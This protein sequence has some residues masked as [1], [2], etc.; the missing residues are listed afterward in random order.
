MGV[1]TVALAASAVAVQR[2]RPEII[3]L[4]VVA[5][6]TFC[7]S[8]LTP[9]VSLLGR[10]PGLVGRV[11]WHYALLPMAFS[12]A[13]LGGIGLNA[14]VQSH[15]D[16]AV[17]RWL[18]SWFA[19]I[20]LILVAIWI[21]GRGQLPR[22]E[23]GIRARSFVWP[24]VDTLVGLFVVGALVIRHRLDSSHQKPKDRMVS[25]TERPVEGSPLSS[26]AMESEPTLRH[27]KDAPAA[28][29]ERVT[30]GEGSDYGRAWPCSSAKASS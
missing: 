20:G 21:F 10:G 11:G 18:A 7:L 16:A 30:L 14:L 12:L 29:V 13:I 24:A 23:A 25:P 5:V 15:E 17:R 26:A 6:M 3:G 27:A 4:G 22:V 9:L 2:H 28:A 19:V 1:I 8:F